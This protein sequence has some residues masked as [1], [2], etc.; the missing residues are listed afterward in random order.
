MSQQR[1][2]L[3]CLFSLFSPSAVTAA[4]SVLSI[5]NPA[6]AVTQAVVLS[7]NAFVASDHVPWKAF[8]DDLWPENYRVRSAENASLFSAKTSIGAG[9]GAI[10]L[11]YFRRAEA[12]VVATADTARAHVMAQRDDYFDSSKSLGIRYQLNGFEADGLRLS[13]TSESVSLPLPIGLALGASVNAMRGLRLRSD[14]ASGRFV[15]DGTTVSLNGSR[16]LRYSGLRPSSGTSLSAFHPFEAG[17]VPDHGAG[18]SFD[19]GLVWRW[20]PDVQLSAAVNDLAGV[21]YWKSLPVISQQFSINNLTASSYAS[22]GAPAVSGRHVYEDY[23]LR[24]NRKYRLEAEY[25]V[26]PQLG[27]MGRVESTSGIYFPMLGLSWKFSD[28][29][30]VGLSYEDRWKSIALGVQWPRGE[31][32][33]QADQPDPTRAR[34]LGV[35]F[36]LSYGF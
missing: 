22:S 16:E 5:D 19:L 6:E 18:F 31:V 25:A 32:A 13:M 7:V 30:M 8:D 4:P 20:R 11:D 2:S 34:A 24:L 29:W 1:I 33:I 15:S 9:V 35:R 21:L 28:D 23:S 14:W 17:D 10:R 3:L 12:I 26:M 27:I 36:G